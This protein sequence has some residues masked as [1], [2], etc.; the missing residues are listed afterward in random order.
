MTR[1]VLKTGEFV[2]HVS[3]PEESDDLD[4]DYQKLSLRESWDFPE[5]GVAAA[6]KRTDTGLSTLRIATT[7]CES[8]PRIHLEQSEAALV[9]WNGES[10]TIEVAEAIR[11]EVKPVNN[12]YFPPAY[13]RKMLR[14]LTKRALKGTWM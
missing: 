12:T 1:N 11:R 5:A 13:R 3:T 9:D 10:T 6:W 8:I 7:A 14:V 2:T 4:G